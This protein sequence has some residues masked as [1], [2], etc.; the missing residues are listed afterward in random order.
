MNSL[1]TGG[2]FGEYAKATG[3]GGVKFPANLSN[4]FD[5]TATNLGEF[6][7]SLES[8]IASSRYGTAAFD[9]SSASPG[10]PQPGEAGTWNFIV[11]PGDIGWGSNAE[12][13]VQKIF[14]TNTPPAVVGTKSMREL[15]LSDSLVEG[16]TRGVQVEGK[17]AALEALMNFTLNTQ[18]GFVN[19]PVY[20]VKA[21][22]KLYGGPDGGFFVMKEVTVKELIRDLSGNATRAKVDVS[23][24]QVPAYQVDS[25]MDQ[26]EP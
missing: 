4:S 24:T 22:S 17:V 19:V 5:P 6:D 25:G 9:P 23:F 14:G 26:N 21:N 3:L 8:K 12:V 16:F 13:N 20:Q 15:K 11:A 7:L 2:T 18:A 1:N 10:G